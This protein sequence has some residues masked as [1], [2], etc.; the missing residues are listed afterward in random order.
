[1]REQARRAHDDL[2]EYR[3]LDVG[4]GQKPYEPIFEPY[5][6][7]YT[8]VDPVENPRAE[9]RGT[10][11]ALPVADGSFELVL[12]NQV[13]EHSED[14]ALAVRE[15]FRAVAPGGRLL[16]TTHG[17]QVYHP[18]PVDYWRWT[19]AG[20]EKILRDNGEW[21]SVSVTPASGTTAC[22]AM[23][24]NVYIDLAARRIHAGL[25]AKPIVAGLNV[26]AEAID[27]RSATLREP[28]PGT[29][30]ANFHVVAE[31]PR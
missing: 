28:G 12:C 30:F 9:L 17:T 29:L 19:H 23:L 13:L 26:I 15:L 20:L 25:L 18:S 14:P 3:L 6:T 24:F 7:S 10:V 11:E 2:G 16:L 22:I 1:L 8:G 4:C 27:G 31:K 21:A 5:A